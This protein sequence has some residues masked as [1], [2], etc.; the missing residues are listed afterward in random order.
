M[1]DVKQLQ[2]NQMNQLTHRQRQAQATRALIV[3]AAKR[4]FLTHGYAATTIDAIAVEAGVA[5]S[6]IYAIFRNKRGILAGIREAWHQESGQRTLYAQ[7]MEEADPANALALAARATRRQWETGGAMTQIYD[8]AA[9]ADPEA[10]EE[11]AKSLEGRRT[12]LTPFVERLEPSLRPG[13]DVSHAAAIFF[14]LTH[15][16]VYQSLVTDAGWSDDEYERWL[17]E[18][19]CHQLLA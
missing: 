5:V 6:T 19:L 10:A 2:P 1:D 4:L 8:A 13:L 15:F 17:A 3:E 14:A 12:N 16:Y 18:S 9:S 11:R 7:A